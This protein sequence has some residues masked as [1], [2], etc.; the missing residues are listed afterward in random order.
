MKTIIGN[1]FSKDILGL[2]VPKI[3]KI[4]KFFKTSNS[5]VIILILAQTLKNKKETLKII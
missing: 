2:A 1:L 5:T 3:L 4:R